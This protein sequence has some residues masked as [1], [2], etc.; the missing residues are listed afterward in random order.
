LLDVTKSTLLADYLFHEQPDVIINCIG[1]LIKGSKADPGNA[2]YINSYLPHFL[3]NEVKKYGSKLI[4]VST[5]CV[6]T[7]DKG[8]YSELDVP[9]ATDT[10]GRSK[11]LGELVNDR[12][13]TLRTSIV[14]PELKENGE[15]LFDWFMKSKGEVK[16][17]SNVYWGGVTT[18]AL[19]KV[20]EQC[21]DENIS[22]LQHVTNGTRI[23]KYD[24]LDCFKYIWNKT[25]VEILP[26]GKEKKDSSLITTRMAPLY[27]G[28]SYQQMLEDLHYWM[29]EHS[30]LYTQYK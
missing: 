1:V 11:A 2:I 28:F 4:H 24:L 14:G 18:L 5:D 23:S 19:A 17:Y 25:D 3:S 7:G 15:G 27:F 16:G 21:I 26:D 22:G 9:D 29:M 30:D 13:L 10:Y 8:W 12:D 20:M 6:F